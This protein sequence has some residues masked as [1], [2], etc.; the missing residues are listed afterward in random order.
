MKR[1]YALFPLLLAFNFVFAQNKASLKGLIVDSLTKAPLEFATV[2]VVN[3]KD[4]SLI[5]YTISEKTGMF[6]LT[7]IPVDRQTKLIVSYIGY[8]VYRMLLTL[9]AGEANDI[10]LVLLSGK[11]LKEVV[12]QGERSPVVMK[13]DTIEFNTEAFKTRPNADVEELLR[14]LP[15][16]Q[17]NVDGGIVINGASASKVLINGKPFFGS[18][19][20]MATK[21]LDADMIDKI[22]VY[23][24]RDDDPT[25]QQSKI[26]VK[27]VINLKLKSAIRKST[28]GK[29]YGGAGTRNRFEAGGVMSTFRDTLQV[30][31]VTTAANLNNTGVSYTDLTTMGGF[32]RSESSRVNARTYGGEY[33]NGFVE[34][35]RSAFSINNNYGEKLKLNL[36]YYNFNTKA[37]RRGTTLT[38]QTLENTL[39]TTNALASSKNRQ[40]GNIVEGLFEW[41]PDTANSIR[42]QP[43]F[44]FSPQHNISLSSIDRFN[45]QNPVLSNSEI[46]N[47]DKIAYRSFS[48]GLSYY[49]RFK[50]KDHTLYINHSLTL[51]EGGTDRY[52]FENLVSNSATQP[53]R[54]FDRFSDLDNQYAYLA[55]EAYYDYRF[56]KKISTELFTNSRYISAADQTLIFDKNQGTG[57]Y[58]D[59]IAVQSSDL[60]R[61]TFIQNIKPQLYY[62]INDNFNIRLGLDLEYQQQVSKFNF[63]LAD[64]KEDFLLLFPSVRIDAKNFSLNYYESINQ[65]AIASIQPITREINPLY[66]IVGNPDLTYNHFHFLVANYSKYIPR[67]KFNFNINS[68]YASTTNDFA[69]QTTL[70]VDGATTVTTVNG[71]ASNNLSLGG[72]IGKQMGNPQKIGLS[73][74][75]DLSLIYRNSN[76]YLNGDKGDQR[77]YSIFANQ[78]ASVNFGTAV[79]L[80]TSYR[81]SGQFVSYQGLSYPSISNYSHTFSENGNLA[82]N[83]KLSITSW[84]TFTYQPNVIQGF[85]KSVH[86]LYASIN[87]NMLKKD[88]AQ[89]RLMVSD[90]LNQYRTVYRYATVNSVVNNDQEVLRRY[91]MLSCQY[92]INIMKK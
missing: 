35:F 71:G 44:E 76:F 89:L 32:N 30:S 87:L 20:T 60:K 78:S 39:L 65:P 8:D 16:V 52:N 80:T 21:N 81:F 33:I 28:I 24:D 43:L 53:S 82:L 67:T 57:L 17:V 56:T 25:H 85:Q 4:T 77:N 86:L 91:V 7:G 72:G 59:F 22:Q 18:N 1:L 83:N 36:S 64:R 10:G 50:K 19:V 3:A 74:S 51:T 27:K 73:F 41:K 6:R 23:D 92:K 61:T 15:G 79:R 14:L 58:Q 38:E 45:T 13:K 48:H 12:I 34:K 2:A 31:L 54:L 26:N 46:N 70:D 88:R 49:R 62:Y 69:Q 63:G 5:A 55:I 37:I 42:Y 66:K 75:S 11:N 47:L 84:Y 29:I 90:L 68:S 9:K 40:N